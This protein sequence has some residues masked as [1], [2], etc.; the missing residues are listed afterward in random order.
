[1]HVN[2]H[3]AK[4]SAK[5]LSVSPRKKCIA[6]NRCKDNQN[7]VISSFHVLSVYAIIKMAAVGGRVARG[8]ACVLFHDWVHATHFQLEIPLT[9][10]LKPYG[11][12]TITDLALLSSSF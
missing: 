2:I 11:T 7:F 3:I 4:Y 10:V 9:N 1:M 12:F 8:Q 5:F 6:R